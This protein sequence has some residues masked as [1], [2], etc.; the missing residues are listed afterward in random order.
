M[1]IVI[2]GEN[3]DFSLLKNSWTIVKL[4]LRLEKGDRSNLHHTILRQT[5]PISAVTAWNHC[6]N[7]GTESRTFQDA[8]QNGISQASSETV[9]DLQTGLFPCL[10]TLCH[11]HTPFPYTFSR[12]KGS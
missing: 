11:N 3:L 9:K 1:L 5:S 4:R 7:P 6:W 12:G 8:L 2:N 10:R